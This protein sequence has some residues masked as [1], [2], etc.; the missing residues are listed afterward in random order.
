MKLLLKRVLSRLP[1]P[2]PVG[3][4]EFQ[5]WSDDIIELS[6]KFADVDSMKFALASQIM[7]LGAQ[8]AYVPKNYFVKSMRKAAA[9]QV[10]SQAFQDVKNKQLEAAKAAEEAAKQPVEVT[11]PTPV[12]T[13]DGQNPKV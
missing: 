12:V 4:S 11:T 13:S 10:A 6:G 1:S 8:Q 7:H 9:N 3:M 2:L 5:Q